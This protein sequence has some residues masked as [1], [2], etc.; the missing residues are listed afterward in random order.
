MTGDQ[1]RIRDEF[2]QRS[3]GPFDS[4][5]PLEGDASTR[6]YFRVHQGNSTFIVC[7]DN[8]LKGNTAE[9]YPFLLVHNLLHQH[10]IPVPEILF[11]DSV[12]GLLIENDCGDLLLEQYNTAA[13]HEDR[14][15]HYAGL[16]DILVRMQS[17]PSDGSLPFT[18]SFDVEKLMF[19]FNFFI[20]HALEGY[21][22]CTGDE[23]KQELHDEFLRISMELYRPEYFVFTHRDFHS[24][25]VLV[26][27]GRVVII[28]F[29]DARLGLPQYDLVS[30]LRDSYY[31]L[32]R[33][34]MDLLKQRY[35]LRSKEAGVHSMNPDEFDYYFDLMA[36]QRNIKALG[37][38]AYQ[39]RH[40][41]R[42]KFSKYIIPTL[43]YLHDYCACRPILKRSWELLSAAVGEL[44]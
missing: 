34:D 13:S 8:A 27:Q 26:H 24:R 7:Y 35:Y 21:F 22:G 11:T 25:N 19:E 31:S 39:V 15:A 4:I 23:V 12:A 3:I 30:I 43:A 5:R 38:F 20:T 29:Q 10:K 41:G 16:L 14:M 33:V 17:I 6:E 9:T 2:V 36:F 44:R 37:T 28:D 42:E 40:F 18:L 1:A 32:P